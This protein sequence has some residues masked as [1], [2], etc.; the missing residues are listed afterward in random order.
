MQQI[1]VIILN[2]MLSIWS[3]LSDASNQNWYK[4]INVS[5]IISK[6]EINSFLGLE[7]T[8]LKKCFK[9]MKDNLQDYEK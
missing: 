8:N 5:Q 2:N 1:C 3:R 7:M 6:L 9:I 4:F